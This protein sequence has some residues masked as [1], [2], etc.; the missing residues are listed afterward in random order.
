MPFAAGA[1]MTVFRDRRGRQVDEDWWRARV[2]ADYA[3]VTDTPVVAPT[4][5]RVCVSTRWV[6]GL[7]RDEVTG[8]ESGPMFWT[9]VVGGVH[10]FWV[11]HASLGDALG[12]NGRAVAALR[13]GRSPPMG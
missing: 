13:E 11:E 1:F 4:G 8:V 5:E 3:R 10:D 6:G 12:F 2:V 9:E 7:E